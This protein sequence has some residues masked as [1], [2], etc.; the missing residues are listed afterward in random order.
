MS[1]P[2][3]APPAAVLAVAT[4]L[5]EAAS[6]GAEAVHTAVAQDG[7]LLGE[8]AEAVLLEQPEEGSAPVVL[9]HAPDGLMARLESAPPILAGSGG[10]MVLEV[11]ETVALAPLF[12]VAPGS[13]LAVRLGT[14]TGPLLLLG[15]PA[16]PPAE[17]PETAAALAAAA[18]AALEHAARRA[19]A[20]RSVPGFMTAVRTL[21]ESLDLREVLD[22]VC[23]EAAALVGAEAAAAHLGTA[24]DGL[25][26]AATTG[27][28]PEALG[29]R[30][31][32]G[33]GLAGR[34]VAGGQAQS[35]TTHDREHEPGDAP[36]AAHPG[37]LA[38]PLRWQGQVR[39]VLEVALPSPAEA[40][41][42]NLGLIEAFADFA[43]AACAN[44]SLHAG[45]AHTARTDGLTGCLN[46]AALQDAL[47]R[48]IDRSRRAGTTFSLVLIDLDDFKE[49]NERQGHLV[50]D[51]V[52]RRVGHALRQGV[53]THD[54]VARYGGDEFAIVAIDANEGAA[55]DIATR[56]VQWLTSMASEYGGDVA[57]AQAR[58][59]AGVAEW[60]GSMSRTELIAEADR[61]LLYGKREGLRGQVTP[62][63]ALPESFRPG[64]FNRVREADAPPPGVEAPAP[65]PREQTEILR[66]RS[67]QLALANELGTR[68][69][70]MTTPGDIVEAAVD[71]L[72]DAFGYFLCSA[73][74]LREDGVAES[75]AE[76]GAALLDVTTG[77]T[78]SSDTGL[79]GRC[80]REGRPVMV[81]DV[82]ADPDYQP[83]PP[84]VRSELCVPVWAGERLW[85][86]LD[87]EEDRLDAFDEEDVRLVSTVADQVGSALRSA[88]LYESLERAYL[89][90]A[91]AL[92]AALEGPGRRGEGHARSIVRHA[93]AVGRELALADE[94]LRALRYGAALHDIGKVAVS[95]DVLAKQGPLS[96]E[97]RHQIERHTI[98]GEQ[99][100]ASIELLA[101]V[102][103]LI[104]HVHERFDGG[105]YPDGLAGEEIPMG[106]RIILAC[107]AWHAMVADRPYRAALAPDDAR[108]ELRG[109]A[110]SQFDPRV[111]EALLAVLD[112]E[113]AAGPAPP[114]AAG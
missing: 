2:L 48:E 94:A 4:R 50:G 29:Y 107:D 77:W 12:A 45:L 69:S 66:K 5:M 67:R 28:P 78:I 83:G 89:S 76:R 21:H 22:N 52:L 19:G 8:A 11:A 73:L 80:L 32:P 18:T 40:T 39:G 81:G 9:A 86:A 113:A 104:R 46:H 1:D 85:G 62:A 3:P 72:H 108:R 92:A 57:P 97:D 110:G 20:T 88:L 36:C 71:A 38:A 42:E 102:R 63:S 43:A 37:A 25:I 33:G 53:R 44:A 101:D 35:R 10:P 91:E 74:V 31:P 55:T 93:D 106:S 56:A 87:I 30:L 34:V 96:E 24:E 41:S 100:I 109:G 65:P 75:V 14:T 90:T 26:V 6:R 70:A 103:P 68:L 27:L 64:R 98:A 51:E 99:I 7:R 58:A 105:G 54:L 114:A 15:Y 17:A 59:T 95:D 60:R 79:V 49:V 112:S 82:S 61:A 47:R 84:G 23:R 111:V 13:V 16:A